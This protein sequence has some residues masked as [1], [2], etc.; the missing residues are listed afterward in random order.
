[1]ERYERVEQVLMQ[2]QAIRLRFDGRINPRSK[3]DHGLETGPG[4]HPHPQVDNHEVRIG[5]QIDGPAFYLHWLLPEPDLSVFSAPETPITRF[6]QFPSI[7]P[8]F[9]P[10]STARAGRRSGVQQTDV[11][12]SR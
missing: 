7:Q 11:F 6:K 12:W 2:E 10:G 3:A 1:M 5:G 9:R 4:I 8:Y